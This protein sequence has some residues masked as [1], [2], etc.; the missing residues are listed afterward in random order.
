MHRFQDSPAGR[1]AS[2]VAALTLSLGW[3]AVPI[4]AADAGPDARDGSVETSEVA[5]LRAEYEQRVATLEARIAAL[6]ERLAEA[7]APVAAPAPAAPSPRP[8]AG[9][10]QQ[11]STYFNPAISVIGNY[12]GV[13]GHNPIENLPNSSLRESELGLQAIVDPYARA[14]FFLSFGEEGVDLEEGYI[15]FT[16]LPA[17]LLAKVGRMRLQFGKINTLHLHSLPWADEPLTAV[18]FLGGEEGWIGS[19]VSIG[20]LFAIG[21]TFTEL[22]L[23]AVRPDTPNLFESTK[24]SDLAYNGHYK[25]FRD[26]TEASNLEVGL[27]Y[28]DGTNGS[29]AG[30]HTRLSGL[31]F[32]YRWKPLQTATY[33]GLVVRG[34]FVRSE[35]EQ[36]GGAADAWGYFLSG[37]YRLARRWWLGGRYEWAERADDANLHDSGQAVVLTFSP[38]EFSQLRGEYRRRLFAERI[39]ADELLMQLQFIIGAHGAHPF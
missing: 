1:R 20:R 4:R 11:S 31:D 7:P 6:E 12:L 17:Q 30:A 15:T 21:D 24:R 10:G 3:L 39:T 22:T 2:L 27:S 16:A 26:L 14:D 33:R 29:F 18:N 28:A 8:A 36:P 25:L 5:T 34:E 23:Q 37:D 13:A 19:G 38:S 35:R 32:T 9:G